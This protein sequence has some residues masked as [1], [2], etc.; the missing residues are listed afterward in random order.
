MF[1]MGFSTMAVGVLPTYQQVGMLAPI[2]LVALRLI[3]ASRL[4]A[5]SPV[6]AR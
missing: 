4:P 2:L 3:Q 6:P 5:K 1:L